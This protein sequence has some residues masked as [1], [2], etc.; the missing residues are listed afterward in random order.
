[1]S[2]T[3]TLIVRSKQNCVW[4]VLILLSNIVLEANTSILDATS[5]VFIKW[6]PCQMKEPVCHGKNKCNSKVPLKEEV[7]TD[8]LKLLWLYENKSSKA[9][10]RNAVILL[11]G[12]RRQC[13]WGS[14]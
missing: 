8:I 11:A 4:H 13:I 5:F 3:L 14:E 7:N 2:T 12:C 1:M 6:H 10:K 9:H